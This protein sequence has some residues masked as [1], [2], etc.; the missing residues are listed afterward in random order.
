MANSREPKNFVESY[1]LQN[2]YQLHNLTNLVRTLEGKNNDGAFRSPKT[3]NNNNQINST[4]LDIN[5]GQMQLIDSTLIE[6]YIKYLCQNSEN[7]IKKNLI[8]YVYPII[9]VFGL[10]GNILS[11]MVMHRIHRKK[12]NFQKFSLNLATLSLADLGVL[13]FGCLRE[14]LDDVHNFDLK[15][16]SKFSCKTTLFLC[17]LFF[18]YSAYLHSFIAGE[19][20]LAIKNPLKYKTVA[21]RTN[22][23]ILMIMFL[24]C[25]VFNMPLLWF[26]NI[27]R[28][29]LRDPYH[30]LGISFI[31]ECDVASDINL[32]FISFDSIFYF[33]IPF[34]ITFVFSFL[35]LINLIKSKSF[36][37][38]NA[39]NGS[40]K[41]NRSD[42]SSRDDDSNNLLQNAKGQKPAV[43]LEISKCLYEPKKPESNTIVLGSN[44]LAITRSLIVKVDVRNT[45]LKNKSSNLKSTLMLMALPISY[46]ITTCPLLIV[47]I[48]AKI[49]DE[50]KKDHNNYDTAYSI[51]TILMYVNSSINILFYVVLGK[52]LRKDFIDLLLIKSLSN[53]CK[54]SNL[55]KSNNQANSL[56]LNNHLNL[57]N[58]RLSNFSN[59]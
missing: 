40:S 25:I 3:N 57:S 9:I 54:K 4:I 58:R 2:G 32:I 23:L 8:K 1:C 15:T 28:S 38:Q 42:I 21:F 53:K 17:Y 30:P 56:A 49:V 26:A 35:T 59:S 14:Y 33:L 16:S 22:K 36:Y 6:N 10:L 46:L 51:A 29:V 48:Q 43:H 39:T 7:E 11:F 45:N 13:L 34:I 41:S 20:W 12:K 52:N 24:A 55:D 44:E 31:N 27:K 5:R 19:R 18:S 47:I 37:T 50:I